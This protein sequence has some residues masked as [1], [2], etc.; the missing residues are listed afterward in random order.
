MERKYVPPA[1]WVSSDAEARKLMSKE[2]KQMCV[3]DSMSLMAQGMDEVERS[4]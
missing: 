3:K 2:R 1:E 4:L